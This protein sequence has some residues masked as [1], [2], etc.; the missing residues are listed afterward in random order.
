[1]YLHNEKL[2]SDCFSLLYSELKRLDRRI[3]PRVLPDHN[4]IYARAALENKFK[5]EFTL[6]EVKDLLK[7]IYNYNP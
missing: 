2:Y 3:D 6:K 7:E 4:V 5:R 1:M